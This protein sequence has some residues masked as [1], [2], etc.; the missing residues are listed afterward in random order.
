[1][2]FFTAGTCDVA[3]TL[4]GLTKT[5]PGSYTYNAALTPT[6]SNV[7]PTRGGTGGGTSITVTGTGFG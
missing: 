6:V 3:V 7:T 1:M 4:N 2:V 5:L